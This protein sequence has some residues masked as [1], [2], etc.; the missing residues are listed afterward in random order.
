MPADA[1][2]VIL[3]HHQRFNG[4]GYPNRINAATGEEMPPLAGRHIPVFSR[5]AI[6][7]DVYDAATSV[8]C[9]S[10]GKLPV[11]AIH[12]MRTLCKGFFD[13]V[14]EQTFYRT[15]PAF[16]I[17][18][19]VTLSDGVEAA[20]VDFSPEFPTRPKVQCLRAADGECFTDPTLEEIDLALHTDLEIVAVDGHDVRPFLRSQE[21]ASVAELV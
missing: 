13:P 12:E 20:V 7:A 15:V 6:I 18:Q 16:P 11:Q 10:P 9:Y 19:V 4:C 2:Q 17:G 14:I 5:I 21:P 1:A 3:N 8:R